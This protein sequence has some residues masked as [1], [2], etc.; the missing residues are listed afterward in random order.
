MK[1]AVIA[2]A[3]LSAGLLFSCGQPQYTNVDMSPKKVKVIKDFGEDAAQM[4]LQNL[5]AELKK[6]LK[7]KGAVGAIEVCSK[8]AM[9]ITQE[10]AE[11]FGDIEIKRTTFKYRNPKNK[12]DQYEAEA[13]KFFEK[14]YKE[15]GKLPPYYIQ[16]LKGEYRYYKPLKIQGVCL[17]CHGDPKSM[18]PKVVK[19]LKELYPNDKATGYKLGDFRGVIRVSI[20]EDVIK[21]SCL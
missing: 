3:V 7:T 15:T 16:K 13:L 18:D 14:T 20:P 8:K 19:K 17:T 9:E 4:L 6:A 11:D 1:K 21:K 12:P 5:K 10:V 2:A